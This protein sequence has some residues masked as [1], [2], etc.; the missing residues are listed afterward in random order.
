[1][2][3]KVEKVFELCKQDGKILPINVENEKTLRGHLMMTFI[4]AA[5]L[6]LMSDELKG[7]SLTLESAFMLLHEQHALVYDNEFIT[8]EPVKKMNEAYKAF[9]IKCPEI[10]S[11]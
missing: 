4:A 7:T 6:K 1:M 8:T 10:I 5:A 2:R 11:R 9:K 3:D